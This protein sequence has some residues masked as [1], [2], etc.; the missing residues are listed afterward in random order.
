MTQHHDFLDLDERARKV[1]RHIVESYISYGEPVG[2]RTLS[3][4]FD[5]SPATIRNVMADLEE[6][7][8]LQAPHI[9]AGRLPTDLGLRYFVDGILEIGTLGDTER[10]AIEEECIDANL[11]MSSILEQA[12]TTLSGLSACAGLVVAPTHAEKTIRHIEFVPLSQEKSM[13]ILVSDDGTVENRI[14]DTLPG[15]TPDILRQAGAFLSEKLHGRTIA[16]MRENILQEL[17]VRQHEIDKLM[18]SL[19]EAGLAAQ[20]GDGKLIVRGRSQLLQD[21]EA[22]KNLERVKDL[23]EQLESQETV[24]KLL[25]EASNAEGVKI[26]IGSENSI[27]EGNGHSLILSP[28]RGTQDNIVGAIGVIGPTRLNYAK[29]IPSI[30]FMA[31]IISR[32]IKSLS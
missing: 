27:F 7:G 26:Y 14:I 16:N 3:K 2:S 17:E 22:L 25:A 15:I 9:S 32:R 20:L 18:G 8:L 29:I 11:S 19:V 13:V 30:D 28:Y 4:S 24:S 1:F 10:A 21:P 6:L 23:M 12:S 31:E 5:V